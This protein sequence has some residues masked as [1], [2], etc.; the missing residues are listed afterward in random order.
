MEAG[1]K[2]QRV[3]PDSIGECPHCGVDLSNHHV[4]YKT[5]SEGTGDLVVFEGQLRVL[6]RSWPRDQRKL[7]PFIHAV[8]CGNCRK[9]LEKVVRNTRL[10]TKDPPELTTVD[11]PEQYPPVPGR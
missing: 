3:T 10:I 5:L 2:E 8:S 7:I 9:S 11:D 6:S 4:K 1:K